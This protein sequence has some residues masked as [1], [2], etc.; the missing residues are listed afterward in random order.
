M[1]SISIITINYNNAIGLQKTIESVLNQNFSD[2]NYII[3]DGNSSDGSKEI[4]E[5]YSQKLA[6]WVSEKDNGVY[7]AMNKGIKVAIGEHLLFLNSGDVFYTADSLKILYENIGADIVYG[8]ILVDSNEKPWVKSYP[9]KLTFGYFI[10]DTLPH[11][12]SL[13]RRSLFNKYGLYNENNK[14]VS[15]WEFFAKVI[16]LHSA[17]YKHIDAVIS[18]FN[19]DGISSRIENQSLIKEEKEKVLI[20]YYSAFLPDYENI[21]N[22]K[23]D[24]DLKTNRNQKKSRLISLYAKLLQFINIK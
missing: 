15:D 14:I 11:P 1:L 7:S 8:N 13:I 4:I 23:A 5:K 12:A 24:L 19:Y 20:N 6:Y 2:Y 16:C 10:N 18:T 3:I 17:T 9:S 21:S 22:L